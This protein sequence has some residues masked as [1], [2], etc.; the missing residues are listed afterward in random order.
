MGHHHDDCSRGGANRYARVVSGL[1]LDDSPTT[2]NT[3]RVEK[4]RRQQQ[5]QYRYYQLRMT[6]VGIVLVGAAPHHWI[7]A[8][9]AAAGVR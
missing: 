4:R 2:D 6:A 1:S 8:P 5:Q 9:I 3:R 7:G